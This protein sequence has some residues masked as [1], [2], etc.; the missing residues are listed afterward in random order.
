MSS[1]SSSKITTPS[2]TQRNSLPTHRPTPPLLPTPRRVLLPSP[3]AI[4][5]PADVSK[6]E[7]TEKWVK[8]TARRRTFEKPNP[9][10]NHPRC[11]GDVINLS[12]DDEHTSAVPAK[13]S[14]LTPSPDKPVLPPTIPASP[15]Y[16]APPDLLGIPNHSKAVVTPAT[17]DLNVNTIAAE[18]PVSDDPAIEHRNTSPL[19]NNTPNQL[20]TPY[21]SQTTSKLDTPNYDDTIYGISPSK[22]LDEISDNDDWLDDILIKTP[23]FTS[24]PKQSAQVEVA[25]S[26]TPKSSTKGSSLFGILPDLCVIT[27]T[28][29]V[30]SSAV[31]WNEL[32]KGYTP[33]S[34]STPSQTR[35]SIINK[36]LDIP[37]GPPEV[38]LPS[39]NA[40]IR[41]IQNDLV[42]PSS[43]KS[44]IPTLSLSNW[45][46]SPVHEYPEIPEFPETEIFSDEFPDSPVLNAH[47]GMFTN[48]N[49]PGY[50]VHTLFFLTKI[51]ARNTN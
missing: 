6:I 34:T 50:I 24:I 33:D 29:N 46:D 36:L 35:N 17:A 37:A 14:K 31:D 23:T 18:P 15:G 48:S 43:S 25:R 7:L 39:L 4:L 5:P 40:S 49:P 10:I 9:N 51:R 2:S 13:K 11:V 32:T 26:E 27:P 22:V 45:P 19:Y 30:S 20:A 1:A 8:L 12:S 47:I 42:T 38:P 44:N 16:P 21:F 28:S 3:R 41:P